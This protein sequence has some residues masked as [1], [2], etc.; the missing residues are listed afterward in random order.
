MKDPIRGLR[1]RVTR[2]EKSEPSERAGVSVGRAGEDARHD[3]RWRPAQDRDDVDGKK[4][5]G[6]HAG[7]PGRDRHESPD[8]RQKPR[9]EDGGAAVITWTTGWTTKIAKEGSG[10]KKTAYKGKPDGDP[11]NSSDA[12]KVK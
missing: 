6:R 9:K 5:T 10:Y 2:L 11:T 8:R 12:E 7:C 3:M 1:S 4:S